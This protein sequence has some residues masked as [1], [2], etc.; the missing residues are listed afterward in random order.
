M[1]SPHAVWTGGLSSRGRPGVH[2]LY[3][4]P[5]MSIA[6]VYHCRSAWGHFTSILT[7]LDWWCSNSSQMIEM[8]KVTNQATHKCCTNLSW[9]GLSAMLAALQNKFK[10]NSEISLLKALQEAFHIL[11]SITPVRSNW[12]KPV[13]VGSDSLMEEEADGRT[14]KMLN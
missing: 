12:R 4:W 1:T 9:F 5:W 8:N 3:T 13:C 14:G 2:T 7:L 6:C 11:D 10:S